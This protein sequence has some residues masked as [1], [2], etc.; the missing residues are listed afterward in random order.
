MSLVIRKEARDHLSVIGAVREL[1]DSA[2]AAFWV[3]HADEERFDARPVFS[4]HCG[5][6]AYCHYYG[7]R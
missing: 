2:R 3:R 6:S 7:A 5:I 1:I 4:K